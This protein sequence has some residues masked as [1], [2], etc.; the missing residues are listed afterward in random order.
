MNPF[1]GL[2]AGMIPVVVVSVLGAAALFAWSM[3]KTMKLDEK[4]Y[5]RGLK[6]VPLLIHLPPAT[7]DIDGEGRDA[8]AVAEEEISEAETMYQ[9]IASTLSKDTKYRLYGQR[10]LAFEIITTSEGVRY[11]VLVPVTL[12]DIVRQAVAASYPTA[13]LEEVNEPNIFNDAGGKTGTVGG[14]LVLK[15]ETYYPIATYQDTKDDAALAILNAL[16]MVKE[17][18]GVTIQILLRPADD[19]WTKPAL[20]ALDKIRSGKKVKSGSGPLGYIPQVFGALWQPPSATEKKEGEIQKPLTNLQLAEIEAIEEKMKH[21]GFDV[22][23]R[24]LA[25]SS[26]RARAE[27]LLNGV[28]AV[29]SQFNS[30]QNNGFRYDMLKDIDGLVT[31]YMFRIF[32]PGQRMILNNVE[33]ASVLHLPSQNAIPTSKVQKQ[34]FK[35]VDGPAELSDE[36]VIL[37]VNEF[38]GE[39]KEIRLSTKDRRRHL[40]MI[41]GTGVGK[42]GFLHNLAYQDMMDGRGFA[43]IDPHGDAV[44]ELM[45]MVPE[46]RIDD[47]IYFDPGDMS[48]PIGLNMF[49]FSGPDQKDFIVNEGVNMLQSLYDPT[50]QG[51][52]GPRGQHM[53]RNAALLLMSDPAGGTFIDVPRCFIDAEFRNDKLKYVT[54]RAV[55][56]YWTKEFPASQKSSEAGEV[57]TW[58]VSKWGPFLSN[59]MMR[60][61]LGQAKSGFDIREIMDSKKILL[62]NLSK[63][64]MGETNSQLLGMIFVMKFQVA[65]MKRADMPEEE[66]QDFC[67]FVDEFQNFSTESFESI[68]SEARKYRL[69]LVLANQFMTQL[70][71]KIREAI[72]GNIGTLI[73]GRIGITDAEL[74][75]KKFR[76]TFVAEDLARL[77]N[78]QAIASVMIYNVPSA[79]FSMT[80]LP[81]M[82]EGSNNLLDSMKA[83]SAATYGRPRAEVDAEIETRL[84]PSNKTA[85]TAEP[86]TV[87]TS[88]SPATPRPATLPPVEQTVGQP[89]EPQKPVAPEPPA[90]KKPSFLESWKAKRGS[91]VENTTSKTGVVKNTTGAEMKVKEAEPAVVKNTTATKTETKPVE[92]PES[93]KIKVADG[94]QEV[95]LKIRR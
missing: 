35:Q 32:P 45:S 24:L 58:F 62:V 46:E 11:Y 44:E 63:G 7:D 86:V 75:E 83:Y 36:G 65:A 68:L 20:Q 23:I 95:H 30:V 91:V 94:A 3:H 88:I 84:A 17:G 43:F 56:D 13:R 34:Q 25:S 9:I 78:Y 42:T 14:E 67:L 19:K 15:K 71:D 77:P 37:G 22:V 50:N 1:G 33:L 55:Y 69:N 92:K 53:F 72:I 61:I 66:R 76:P 28:V 52:F 85:T 27:A 12:V 31:N 10:H 40:Y 41:G 93:A 51:F 39:K 87:A 57:I 5:E 16:S 64:K 49:E 89:V 81:P 47:V 2:D 74:L 82:G 48:N 90:P 80:L 54:D 70:T 18:D 26:T 59:Q 21:P 38:R 79:P 4:S 8:R 6:L 29:F 60:N 73:S